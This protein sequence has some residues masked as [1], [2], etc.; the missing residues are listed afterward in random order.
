MLECIEKRF[1]VVKAPQPVEWLSDNGSCYTARETV[2]FAT[3]L[4]LLPQKTTQ[5]ALYG[6]RNKFLPIKRNC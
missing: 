3:L 6:D 2:A 1:G 4:G 5:P